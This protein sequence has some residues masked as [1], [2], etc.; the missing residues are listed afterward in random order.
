MA[1]V[2]S[3]L[4]EMLLESFFRGY[5]RFP[6]SQAAGIEKGKEVLG[7]LRRFP[8]GAIGRTARLVSVAVSVGD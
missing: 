8:L 2:V 6:N 3:E 4:A 5:T 7:A 1:V